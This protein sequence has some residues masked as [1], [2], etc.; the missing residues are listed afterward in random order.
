MEIGT[1]RVSLNYVSIA[2]RIQVTRVDARTLR[3][4]E[5]DVS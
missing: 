3:E 4:T 2:T 5:A 1:K